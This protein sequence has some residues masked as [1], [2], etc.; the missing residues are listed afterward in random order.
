MKMLALVLITILLIYVAYDAIKGEG[1]L[2]VEKLTAIEKTWQFI[3]KGKVREL[4][5]VNVGKN[6][7]TYVDPSIGVVVTVPIDDVEVVDATSK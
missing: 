6:E 5:A 3:Y 7:V 2:R 1:R 4:K